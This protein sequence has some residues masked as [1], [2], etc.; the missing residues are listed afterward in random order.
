MNNTDPYIML[1]AQALILLFACYALLRDLQ[2]RKRV[3]R[4]AEINAEVVRGEKSM[5]SL[6]TVYGATIA[7]CLVLI[8]KAQG[9]EGN[10]VMFIIIDFLCITYVF[11][12]NSWFR[13]SVFFPLKRRI[14]ND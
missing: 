5:G 13:N 8:D 7:S 4:G 12:F 2:I 3:K 9:L 10:K 14:R 1:F 11:F 6:F